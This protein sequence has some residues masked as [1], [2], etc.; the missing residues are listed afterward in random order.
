MFKKLLVPAL[1]TVAFL[2][3][4]CGKKEAATDVTTTASSGTV[5][6]PLTGPVAV[7]I[8]DFAYSPPRI[9]V[10]KGTVITITNQDIAGHTVTA[11]DSSFDTQT[12]SKG[13]SVSL[14]MDTVGAFSIHCI[15]HP[16]ITG[17]ITVVE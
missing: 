8:K 15:P 10:K 16:Q 11:D 3:A 5:E 1:I 9:V 2:G 14:T 13:K 12:I 6:T 7:M 4:A 17:S